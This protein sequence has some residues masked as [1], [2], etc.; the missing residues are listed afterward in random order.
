VA[1]KFQHGRVFLAGDAAHLFTPAGGLGYNTAIEDAVNLGWKLAAAVRGEGGSEL[2]ASYQ[3]E[4][5]PNAQRNTRYAKKFAESLG[6]F[7]P[8]AEIEDDSPEGA[9]ARR[10]AG[11][12]LGAHG[13]AEFNIPGIT[14]GTRYASSII[15][16]DET[17]PPPDTAND[18]IPSAC[19]GGRAPHLWLS[20]KES[21][22]DAFG[23]DWTLLR[24]SRNSD[25]RRLV[26]AAADARIHLKIVDLIRDEA[27]DIYQA[28]LVL[29]RPD[30]IVAWR[31][32][33]DEAAADIVG[34]VLGL[35]TSQVCMAAD[36]NH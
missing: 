24:L 25:G 9:A 19:P 29:I 13:K 7:V 16:G 3:A 18:Y 8:A 32:N 23:F 5:R 11:D 34:C 20:A 12:Y 27:R 21:L 35:R 10:I 15:V 36:V 30:Q 14:F 33:S 6:L 31:G 4:R 22:Y 28:D 1:E 26:A 2:L 17:E